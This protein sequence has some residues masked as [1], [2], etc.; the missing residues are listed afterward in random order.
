MRSWI[1][2][3]RV[4][5]WCWCSSFLGSRADVLTIGWF[6]EGKMLCLQLENFGIYIHISVH[7]KPSKAANSG[8]AVSGARSTHLPI[9]LTPFSCTYILTS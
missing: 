9:Y 3:F 6:S 2:G 4:V 1:L 8:T 5:Y 7:S